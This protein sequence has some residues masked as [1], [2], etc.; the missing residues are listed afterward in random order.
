MNLFFKKA[1]LLL[2]LIFLLVSVAVKSAQKPI[3]FNPKKGD[4]L[5][6]LGNTFADRMRYYGYFETLLQKSFPDKQLTVRNMGWSGDEPALQPR[7]L[8]FSSLH[9]NLTEQKADFIFLCFGMNESFKGK[10]GLTSYEKDLVAFINDLKTHKY[11]GLS[12]PQ[13]IL[14]SPIAHEALGGYLPDPTNHNLDLALYTGAMQRIAEENNILFIDLFHP[15]VTWMK[16]NAKEPLTING[17]HLNDK[18]YME[19]GKWMAKQLGFGVKATAV[20]F[21]QASN[22]KLE[23]VI[24]LKDQ[25]F[26]YRWRAV[27]GEYIYGRRKEPFGVK[28]YPPEIAKL[29]KMLVQLDNV[30]WQMSMNP[31]IDGYKKAMSIVDERSVAVNKTPAKKNATADPHA[32]HSMMAANAAKNTKLIPAT[33]AQ[34]TVPEGYEVNLFASEKDFPVE[35]PVCMAFDAKGRLWMASMP[36]YPQHFP[37]FMP[38]DKIVIL[39]DTNADGRADKHTVFA[40]NLYLPLGFDFGNGGVYVSQEPDIYFLKDT[41][42][43]DKADVREVVLMGF[44]SEDS[45][46]A[47]HAYSYGQDGALYFN[48]G[49][50]LHSQIETPYGPVRSYNGTTFRFEPRTWKV[51]SYIS[52]G[53]DN[54]WG[55]VFDKWGMHLIADASNG[56]N[57][58]ATPMTGKIDYPIKHTQINTFTTTRVRPTAGIEYIS[59]RQFPDSVQGDV[60][61]N[62]T[63]GFQGIKHHKVIVTG[64]GITSKEVE[65]MLQSSDPNFRPVDLK[66]GPDG[67][68]YVADWYNP[69]IGHMQYSLRD[70]G[71]DKSHGRIWR[72]TYKGKPV[73]KSVDISKQEL[74]ELFENLK[75]YEDRFRYRSRAK[76]R[77]QDPRIVLP[78]MEKWVSGQDKNDSLYEHSL[79]EALWLYQDFD[80]VKTDLLK[81]LLVAKDYR[82][83][84]AATRVLLYWKD[85]VE[86]SLDLLRERINDDSPRVRLEAIVALS[87]YNS[88]KAITAALDIL[89]HPT[90]YYLEYGINETLDY[91]K[92]VWLQSFKKNENFLADNPKAAARLLSY[93]SL[94][95]RLTLPQTPLVLSAMLSNMDGTR[96]QK[97]QALQSLSKQRNTSPV[98]LIIEAIRLLKKPRDRAAPEFTPEAV[99]LISI[100][101]TWNKTEL[102]AANTQLDE[103]LN[104]NESNVLQ[105][106]GYAALI[107]SAGSD[108][109]VWPRATQSTQNMVNYLNGISLLKDSVLQSS[110]Y[111]KVKTLTQEVPLELK[112]LYPGNTQ[113]DDSPSFNGVRSTAYRVLFKIPGNRKEKVELVTDLFQPNGPFL[114]LATDIISSQKI[115]TFSKAEATEIVK[116][117]I[118]V[119]E[120]TAE[121]QKNSIQYNSTVVLGKNLTALLPKKE[122]A[123]LLAVLDNTGTIEI[124]ITTLPAKMLFDKN[125]IT[126]PSGRAIT[127]VFDNPDQMPHN[128][129]IMKPGAYEKVGKAADAMVGLKDGFEK[130]F[131][132]SIPE[133]LF[134]TPLVNTGK[135]FRLNFKAPDTPGDYPFIC[136]FPGHWRLM[137]GIFRVIEPG[138]VQ[139]KALRGF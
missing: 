3:G 103:L 57:Y 19:T 2:L 115:N 131:V 44:G 116:N 31:A 60:L 49:T 43:D 111:E 71:R 73:L 29:N 28:S 105:A 30:I 106:A 84:A 9:D 77:E 110:F 50:F 62:N 69:L 125:T 47:T 64:S 13:L 100:L 92:P 136:S 108:K 39:E 8:N 138:A 95:E 7:P 45:H 112:K 41:T 56:S 66:F 32:K 34:F 94:A 128:V 37:G 36:T 17:I 82:A 76:I 25:H 127:L 129:V 81:K 91:L 86:N 118:T 61:I 134:A 124:K 119:T 114:N 10:D 104:K 59:S 65:P 83:R 89:N 137:K 52:Y 88:D 90:D 18:G 14:V 107:T 101:L 139:K 58:Y 96:E 63:I 5:I 46:H 1:H 130:N 122:A 23:E 16:E 78:A 99:D 53:Y 85:R 51:S 6:F 42:G 75:A 135:S 80:S 68:L 22:K 48:E 121:K 93:T 38:N 11:N 12:S 27:N 102:S 15:C 20:N 40:D 117:I 87:Y 24:R 132:P 26:L 133:V 33:T 70:P 98:N 123:E 109:P 74:P 113:G 79:L 54:P 67:A 4:H 21:S 97:V 55:N 72:I 35:K 120:G 126:I